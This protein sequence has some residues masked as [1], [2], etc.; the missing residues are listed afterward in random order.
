MSSD[1][2][3]FEDI[4]AAVAAAKAR[5]RP[6]GAS[7]AGD[8]ARAEPYLLTP[9]EDGEVDP[10]PDIP[11]LPRGLGEEDDAD[12]RRRRR[13][14]RVGRILQSIVALAMLIGFGALVWW[15]YGIATS[16]NPD[17]E[18]P[19]ITAELGPEKVRP[20]SEGGIEVPNQDRLIYEEITPGRDP[21]RVESLLPEPETPMVPPAPE[22]ETSAAPAALPP[23]EAPPQT[24]D[25]VP[26]PVEPETEDLPAEIVSPETATT[27]EEPAA[28]E[29]STFVP[30][31]PPEPPA[32]LPQPEPEP[33]QVAHAGAGFRVQLAA[34]KTP[35]AARESWGRLQRRHPDALQGLALTVEQ[36]DL[37]ASGIFY[38]V[39]AGPL[40]TRKAAE[41]LCV[42]LAQRDQPCL[43]VAP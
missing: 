16:G 20:E 43:V 18:I 9:I 24:V 5:Q 15:G 32:M 25:S 14:W 39:Q 11:P 1:K 10:E 40:A 7:P 27:P 22:P 33:S 13:P 4:Q 30:P 17:A 37:G 42:Q 8:G 2:L 41:F 21:A 31:I 28:G 6:A 26:V 3:S 29:T 35:A 38:R 36:A 34:F 12:G 19:V 23:I